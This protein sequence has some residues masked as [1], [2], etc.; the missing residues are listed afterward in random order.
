MIFIYQF[1][2]QEKAKQNLLASISG[3]N[4]PAKVNNNNNNDDDDDRF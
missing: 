1:Y 4:V 2:S 3:N